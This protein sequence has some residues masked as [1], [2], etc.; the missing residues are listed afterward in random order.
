MKQVVLKNHSAFWKDTDDRSASGE[1]VEI[2]S[3][4][5]YLQCSVSIEG[6]FLFIDLMR[7]LSCD[8]EFFQSVF[9]VALGGFPLSAY[10]EDANKESTDKDKLTF[11][12]VYWSVEVWD[13]PK[14]K[15]FESYAGF[16]GIGPHTCDQTGEHDPLGRWAIEFSPIA[17]YADVPIKIDNTV[18]IF[19]YEDKK[20]VQ[21]IEAGTRDFTLYDLIHAILNEISFCG[22]P[23][24]RNEQL[25]DLNN[26][27]DEVKENIRENGTSGFKSFDELMKEMDQD[28]H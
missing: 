5:R 27:V 18:T 22:L 21:K 24:D 16:H 7:L 19:R 9:D 26:R 20:P 17:D 4:E 25:E 14:H 8:E 3:L 11:V 28:E 23:E 2:F 15:S 13:L 12:E 6:D 1:E 10:I